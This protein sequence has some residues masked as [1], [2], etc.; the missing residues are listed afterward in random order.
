MIAGGYHGDEVRAPTLE[1]GEGPIKEPLA[2]ARGVGVVKNIPCN[3]EKV[4]ILLLEH[5][6]E[7]RKVHL[8][9]ALARPA[10]QGLSDVPVRG[11]KCAH[12]IL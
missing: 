6:C 3:K 1:F 12:Q 5:I 7:P 4:D 9:L 8:V 11:V 2:F 10:V